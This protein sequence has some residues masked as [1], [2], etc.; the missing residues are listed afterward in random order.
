LKHLEE[1]VAAI[2]VRLA[3]LQEAEAGLKRSNDELKQA[4]AA[5]QKMGAPKS[6]IDAKLAE[7]WKLHADLSAAVDALQAN[8]RGTVEQRVEA[9]SDSK[10]AVEQRISQLAECHRVTEAIRLDLQELAA[11]RAAL[12]QSLTDAEVDKEGVHLSDRL[13]E[14]GAFADKAHL[15][16]RNLH[17]SLDM[18][19]RFR[20]V[21]KGREN[22]VLPMHDSVRGIWAVYAEATTVRD[23]LN[24]VLDEL[25]VQEGHRLQPQVEA[26]LKSKLDTE[27]RAAELADCLSKLNVTR[28]DISRLFTR[29]SITLDRHA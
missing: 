17:D 24:K 21:L 22:E 18:L 13:Q 26:L 11:R 20:D 25:E 6:G 10:A 15:R 4:Q 27:Q 8:E 9:L 1:S 2:A 14:L 16:S 28:N 7:A 3:A 5:V 12:E 29:L 23:R 19:N